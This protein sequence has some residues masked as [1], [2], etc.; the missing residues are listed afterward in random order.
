MIRSEMLAR[1]SMEEFLGWT[2]WKQYKDELRNGSVEQT[3]EQ[4]FATLDR[5]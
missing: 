5:L 2:A 1:M 3:P 4:I